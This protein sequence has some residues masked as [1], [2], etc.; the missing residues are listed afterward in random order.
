[1]TFEV[2]SDVMEDPSA[3]YRANAIDHERAKTDAELD[4]LAEQVR[5]TQRFNLLLKTSVCFLP[6]GGCLGGVGLQT[7]APHQLANSWFLFGGLGI[8]VAVFLLKKYERQ[9]PE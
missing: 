5:S 6:I 4:A 9:L 3:S 8:A 7:L 2:S 1:M